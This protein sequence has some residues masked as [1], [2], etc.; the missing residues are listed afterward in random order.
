MAEF[1]KVLLRRIDE[2]ARDT[3]RYTLELSRPL[4]FQAGQ[5]INLRVPGAKPRGERSYSM[6]SAPALAEPPPGSGG[7]P[8][9]ELCIKLFAGGAASE[10]LRER[11]AG[12]ELEIRGPFGVFTLHAPGEP[13]GG[14]AGEPAGEPAEPVTFVATS[15]GLAPFRSMLEV[16]RERGDR[17]RFRLL[18]GVRAEED[19]FGLE[20]LARFRQDLDFDYHLCLSQPGDSWAAGRICGRDVRGRVTALLEEQTAGQPPGQPPEG[21]WY[22]CG[23]GGM[24]EAVRGVLKGL[25]LDRKRIHVEK[26]W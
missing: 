19:V 25:G 7:V 16:C 22:L 4:P 1:Q 18:F 15:T 17:R 23:N 14:P 5:F 20:D 10:Y 8:A 12:D 3:N 21:H 6:W 9:L 13:A 11:R 24:I 26:Y 2:V